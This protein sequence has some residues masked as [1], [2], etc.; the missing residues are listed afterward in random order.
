[1]IG[2]RL[3]KW[4]IDKQIGH[5][6]MGRVFLAHEELSGQQAAVKV[7]VAE[8]AQEPGFLQRF[9]REVEVLG[10]LN[11][12][13]IV[14]FY[15]SGSQDGMFFYAM[16][17]VNGDNLE[18]ILE[19]RGRL[20]WQE[21]LDI[22]LQIC[23]ALKHA[24]DHGV[25]HRD[26]KPPNLMRTAGGMIKLTDFGIAK[27]FAG[28]QLTSTGGVVGTMEYLSPEQ[29]AGK[30]ATKRSD[31]YSLGIVLYTFL[32]GKP[33]F[34]GQTPAEVL[35]K[36][37]YARFDRPKQIVPDLP[38]ELDDIICQLLEKDPAR[39]PADALVLHRQFDSVWRKLERKRHL[40]EQISSTSR[41]VADNQEAV[42]EIDNPGP[43]TLMSQMMR[44]ELQRQN[45]AGTL[46]RWLNRPWVLVPLLLVCAGLLAWQFYPRS[47]LS[48]DEL[49]ARGSE[50]MKSQDP[51]DWDKAM[52]EYLDPL[53]RAYPDHP[54]R[55]KVEEFRRQLHD[56]GALR[57]ALAGVKGEGGMS[58]AQRFYQRGIRLCQ[59]GEIDA[60]RRTWQSVIHSFQGVESEA[61]W[62]KQCQEAVE[63]LQARTPQR[64]SDSLQAALQ[65]ARALRDKGQRKEA[66]E[67]WQGLEDLYRG[68]ETFADKLKEVQAD[69][70]KR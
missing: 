9:E 28:R 17:Y 63:E 33:P 54:S 44:E 7:L 57:R 62:V 34:E 60:A 27:I 58:E 61:R 50:L 24:H 67:I 40:T 8:L 23:P 52:T 45:Q 64:S 3:D 11:H 41:T 32:C 22:A 46:A 18:Q 25:I 13:N 1:M 35:H 59:A 2:Q 49:F 19:D 15:E 5:G 30:Q 26:L 14:H 39:R 68:D 47:T 51:S 69:R 16:E 55:Q 12:P 37:L 65:R 56:R 29:A 6:G 48:A 66:E 21:V 4:V 31:L 38:H 42:S 36:H 53:D 43:A 20:P 70:A 10:R